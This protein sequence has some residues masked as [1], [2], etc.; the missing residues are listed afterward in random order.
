MA[1]GWASRKLDVPAKYRKLYRRAMGGK[2]RKAA[3]RVHCLMCVGWQE[4]EIDRCTAP[5]CPLYPYRSTN[6]SEKA[7]N[8]PLRGGAAAPE[9]TQSTE[10]VS[11]VGSNGNRPRK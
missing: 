1:D 3:V 9:S 10:A 11:H 6:A 7:V 5:G 4:R 2:S 8:P